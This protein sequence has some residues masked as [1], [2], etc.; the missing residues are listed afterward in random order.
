MTSS[1]EERLQDLEN[2]LEYEKDALKDALDTS[3]LLV[4]AI[5]VFS[6]LKPNILQGGLA[7][8]C[9]TDTSSPI[10]DVLYTLADV[11][12]ELLFT[13]GALVLYSWRR[14]CVHHRYVLRGEFDPAR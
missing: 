8:S 3:F 7:E 14:A 4:C 1:L 12:N 2:Q 9:A 6:E 5:F 13:R 10:E 11:S